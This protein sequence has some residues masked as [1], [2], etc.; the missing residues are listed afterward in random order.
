MTD[1]PARRAAD[2]HAAIDR[3]IA[4]AA[5]MCDNETADMLAELEGD[6]LIA[7][8]TIAR[9]DLVQIIYEL[10]Y[11]WTQSLRGLIAGVD[12]AT[13]DPQLPQLVRGAL[14]EVAEAR[15]RQH[16]RSSS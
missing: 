9:A 16:G 13:D 12:A 14:H 6:L 7:D 4:I 5:A 15:H 2:P 11:M 10:A 3:A 1:E 8:P